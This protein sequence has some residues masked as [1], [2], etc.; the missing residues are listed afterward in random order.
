MNSTNGDS[1]YYLSASELYNINSEVTDGLTFVR[2]LNLLNSA[3]RRP[4]LALFGEPQFPALVDKAAAL[5]HSL[6]YHHLFA[7]GNK[8]TA[9]RAVDLFLQAN[10]HRLNW[11]DATAQAYILEVAQ[12]KHDAEAVALFLQP[13][14]QPV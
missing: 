5:M 6:A 3:A 14:L 8:R 9:R 1:I 11:D 2:D 12:G 10:R 4:M 13:F 7:D